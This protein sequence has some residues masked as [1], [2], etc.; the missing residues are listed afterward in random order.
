[1]VLVLER[2]VVVLCHIDFTPEYRF[3]IRILSG[4]L[5]ELLHSVHVS[6]V[7]YRQ[8]GHSELGCTCEQVAY[9]RLAVKN[10]V[11]GV[12]VKMDEGHYLC[13][14]FCVR[15]ATGFRMAGRIFRTVGKVMQ[16]AFTCQSKKNPSDSTC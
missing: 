2:V 16:K 15:P 3:H 11:L 12:Y 13:L 4:C 14:L 10:G 1:M 5:H 9:G 6:V 7:S 8:C